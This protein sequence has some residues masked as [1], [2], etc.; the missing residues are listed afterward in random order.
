MVANTPRWIPKQEL[1]QRAETQENVNGS[2]VRRGC[3]PGSRPAPR[4]KRQGIAACGTGGGKPR[5]ARAP[6]AMGG[7][8][9]PLPD[10]M[11]RG[12]LI[13]LYDAKTAKLPSPAAAGLC[14]GNAGVGR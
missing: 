5:A 11:A 14:G 4:P 8:A 13:T 3:E 7:A 1:C 9:R 6:A 12:L 10:W 2:T